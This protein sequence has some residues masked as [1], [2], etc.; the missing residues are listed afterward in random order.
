MINFTTSE[1]IERYKKQSEKEDIFKQYSHPKIS[2]QNIQ[3]TY[4]LMR[5]IQTTNRK[6]IDKES[7]YEIHR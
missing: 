2:I 5:K 4:K 1:Q 6:N 3:I 7:K